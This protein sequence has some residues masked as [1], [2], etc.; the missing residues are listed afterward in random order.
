MLPLLLDPEQFHTYLVNE[1]T[2]DLLIVDLGSQERFSAKHLPGAVLVTPSQ[3]QA[4]K[5]IPG[6]IPDPAALQALMQ[7]IGYSKDKHIVVY[8]D[9]G[10]G[11]AGRFIWMLDE[12]G[13]QNYSY[14][15]GGIIAWEA[16]GFELDTGDNDAESSNC[17]VE[18][19]GS[20][21]IT[22]E[23]LMSELDNDALTIWDAR[24]PGEHMGEKKNANRAG[25]I[26]GAKN[27]EWTDAMDKSNHLRLKPLETLRSELL[28]KGISMDKKI[29]T[30]CQTHHRSG[31]TYLIAKLLEAKDV[32]AYAGSWGEWG[33]REDT[34]IDV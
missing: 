24:S 11:W 18:A 6:F 29:V 20:Y 7:S 5:P 28:N 4:G 1:K 21:T 9:E 10:G 13:H 16:L 17:M 33:N 25:R 12:I 2:D 27:Y 26:P 30:H 3:T 23:T 34:P 15:D 31:L 14:L 8:D 32:L 19:S 22:A